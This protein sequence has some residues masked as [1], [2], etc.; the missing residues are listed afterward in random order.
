MSWVAGLPTTNARIVVT[1]ALAVATGIRYFVGGWSPSL[2]WLAFLLAMA[3]L[4]VAQFTSKR[5]TD[6]TYVSAKT[7]PPTAPKTAAVLT[8]NGQ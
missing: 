5:F 4:D 7:A 3:G 1:L 8:T 2:E 6:A